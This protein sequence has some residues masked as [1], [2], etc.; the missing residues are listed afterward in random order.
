MVSIEARSEGLAG[1]GVPL[2][3]HAVRKTFRRRRHRT[4]SRARRG[5]HK[6]MHA[7]V[8]GVSF[9]VAPGE[10]Y[11]LIGANGSGKSTLIRSLPRCS[12]RIRV[13]SRSSV[14]M[15]CGPRCRCRPLLNRVSAD[16]SF[17]RAMSP[18]ENLLFYGRA[19]GLSGTDVRRRSAAILGVS[20]SGGS[21]AR[22][23]MLHLSRGQQQKVA[24]AR[25]F[26]SIAPS[27]AARRA[28][29]RAS[30]RAASA[31]SSGSSPRYGATTGWR[32]C[33]RPTTWT[34]PNCCVTGL[35]SSSGGRLVSEGTPL[36]LRTAVAGRERSVQDVDMEAVFMALT[37][38]RMRRTKR[39][40]TRKGDAMEGPT[41]GRVRRCR[42]RLAGRPG[43]ARM[44]VRRT[45][46]EPVEAAL[47]LGARLARLRRG[48]HPGHH[49]HRQGGRPSGPA[50]P[51]RG[52]PT[53]AVPPDRHAGVGV[54][55]RRA[56]RHEPGDH[57]GALGRHHRAHLHDPGVAGRPSAR[58]VGVRCRLHGN[59]PYRAHPGLCAA[60][61]RLRRSP[62]VDG[63]RRPW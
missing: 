26:L 50:R 42:P 9:R 56:R 57:V 16:P 1:G 37:G 27:D 36:E 52:P 38:R 14:A 3:V 47:G 22:E 49:L 59:H 12:S 4:F 25:A 46:D 33:S 43:R 2:D 11:G 23:P 29:H 31:T 45:P 54:H 39:K 28:D 40:T 5:Q 18:M 53:D 6:E 30:T 63:R 13:R 21:H 32:S 61:L 58:H 35:P 19:Y 44:G 60:L 17:F 20:A 24:V 41:P 55:V 48:Q 8:D 34:R 62:F 7:A 10:I 51:V 15:R